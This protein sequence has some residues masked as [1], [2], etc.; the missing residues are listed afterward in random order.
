MTNVLIIIKNSIPAV[1]FNQRGPGL[2]FMTYFF[3]CNCMYFDRNTT[4]FREV[5]KHTDHF[6]KQN[7]RK[8]YLDVAVCMIIHLNIFFPTHV[9]WKLVFRY[10]TLGP[11]VGLVRL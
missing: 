4:F 1:T 10:G 9:L 3:G 7:R 8:Q 5:E 11:M 2:G 6:S